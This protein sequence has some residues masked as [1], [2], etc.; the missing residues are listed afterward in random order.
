MAKEI[1]NEQAF[2]ELMEINDSVLEALEDGELPDEELFS[3]IYY[4]APNEYFIA[5]LV[6]TINGGR[7]FLSQSINIDETDDE[8]PIDWY[9][10]LTCNCFGGED[11]E[12]DFRMK[13]AGVC[14]EDWFEEDEEITEEYIKFI[15]EARKVSLRI[16]AYFDHPVEVF[17]ALSRVIFDA[18][19]MVYKLYAEI[20]EGRKVQHQYNRNTTVEELI[21]KAF[22]DVGYTLKI[23][24]AFDSAEIDNE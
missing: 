13:F 5:Q 2:E 1:L 15:K 11:W 8:I 12:F 16:R 7:G 23:G 21:K 22:G 3:Q 19:N 10:S 17:N 20:V 18:R 6:D 14:F 24:E 9:T 4:I